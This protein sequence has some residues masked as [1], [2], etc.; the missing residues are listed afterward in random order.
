[1][2]LQPGP[3]MLNH[4]KQVVFAVSTAMIASTTAITIKTGQMQPLFIALTLFLAGTGP[5]LSWGEK[6]Q[7]LLSLVAFAAFGVAVVSLPGRAF[8]PYQVV[9]IVIAAAIGLFSTALEKRL[10]RARWQAEAEVLKSRETLLLQERLR[11]AGQLASGIAHD[12]NNTLN[13][14]KL[15]LAAL[16]R[17]EDCRE[18]AR[19]AAGGARPRD[20]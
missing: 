3:W 12:L 18:P 1:M 7:A 10:R 6:A 8:N 15:R 11:L 19:R 14:V 20:R 13:V 5:F 9:G 2:T 4:W 16:S 17:E